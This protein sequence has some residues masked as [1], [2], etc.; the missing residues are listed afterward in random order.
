M[1]QKQEDYKKNFDQA[2]K[3]VEQIH[4]DIEQA[5]DLPELSRIEA[6]VRSRL[7][8]LNFRLRGLEYWIKGAVNKRTREINEALDAESES[9]LQPAGVFVA[10][11]VVKSTSNTK[12]T[13]GSKSTN[14]RKK[15]KS[16]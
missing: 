8:E 9:I 11:A 13:S 3:A 12:S 6:N 4:K 10:E 16:K 2:V 1:E 14:S 5:Q 15:T 7:L